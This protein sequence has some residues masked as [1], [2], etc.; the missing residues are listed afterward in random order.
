MPS[1]WQD[2][3]GLTPEQSAWLDDLAHGLVTPGALEWVCELIRRAEAAELKVLQF[4]EQ[5]AAL[6]TKQ[7]EELNAEKGGAN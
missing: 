1:D 6:V 7:R 4:H 5:L 2:I 3:S